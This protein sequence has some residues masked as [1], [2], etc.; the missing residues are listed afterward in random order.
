LITS[1]NQRPSQP[2]RS[3]PFGEVFWSRQS[4]NRT[5]WPWWPTRIRELAL[6]GAYTSPR[7]V[8]VKNRTLEAIYVIALTAGLRQ[9]ELLGLRWDDVD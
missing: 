3:H 2:I 7:N 6:S 8:L 5:R 9:G 1:S 4:K